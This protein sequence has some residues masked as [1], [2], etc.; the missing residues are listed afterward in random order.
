MVK[1]FSDGGL[2]W[3]LSV[4]DAD[5]DEYGFSILQLPDGG[6]IMGG[7]SRSISTGDH[8]M[9]LAR[10]APPEGIEG[11]GNLE[12]DNLYLSSIVPNPVSQTANISFFL[13]ASAITDISVLDLSGRVVSYIQQGV[14]PAGENSIVW[15]GCSQSGF[16]VSGGIYLI[17]IEFMGQIVTGRLVLLR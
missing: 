5:Y 7:D 12:P 1:T 16:P 4:G 14:M 11:E 3:Q 13:P 15:N 6:F 17:R 9:F 8:N 10:L 2:D